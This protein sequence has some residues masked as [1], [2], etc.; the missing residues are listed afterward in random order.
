MAVARALPFVAI[1]TATVR[2]ATDDGIVLED[3]R[4]FA[5]P[6]SNSTGPLTDLP[7]GTAITLK[8]LGCPET[9]RY[10]RVHAHVFIDDNGTERWFQADLVARGLARVSSR[11]GDAGLR[12]DAAR[13]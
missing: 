9:D 3:G 11:V 10:G 1:G 8:R 6:G 13:T 12:Q 7:S 5:S 4:T 2:G